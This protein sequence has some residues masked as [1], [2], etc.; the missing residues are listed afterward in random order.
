MKFRAVLAA[1]LLIA[2]GCSE[3]PTQEEPTGDDADVCEQAAQHRAECVGDYVTPPICEG[4]AEAR[5]REILET[6]CEEFDA[7]FVSSGKADGAFC[8]WFG[9]GCTA[10]EAIF[11]GPACT[12]DADCAGGAFCVE[13]HCFE[14]VTSPEFQ[15]TLDLFTE[16]YEI[17]GGQTQLLTDNALTRQLRNDLV[18]QAGESVHFSAFVIKDDSMG[19]EMVETFSAAAQRGVDV[20]VLIDANTQYTQADYQ[21]LVDMAEAGVQILAW[22]PATEWAGLRL[23]ENFTVNDRMHEKMLI[24]DG[25]EAVIGGRNVGDPYLLPGRWRDTD[26]YVAGTS[27]EG[28]QRLFLEDWD[29]VAGYE[30]A[31]GCESQSD[32]GFACPQEELA[33]DAA[34]YPELDELGGS[35]TR[36]IFS[37]PHNQDTPYGYLTTLALIR[38]ARKSV[39]IANSYFVPPRR[40]RRHLKAAAARGVEVKVLTNSLESTD[41][42]PMYYASLNFYKELIGAGVEIYQYGGTEAMHAKTMLIDDEVAVIGSFNLDPRSAIDNT[43]SMLLVR[44]GAAVQ[45]LREA[46]VVDFAYS[47]AASADI[48]AGEL[49]KAKAWRLAEPLL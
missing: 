34:Q 13:E 15:E 41:A 47:T 6:P 39:T 42:W 44:E 23:G 26:V 18:N 10:D 37:D 33:E 1:T 24:V 7:E 21:M 14:G 29:R 40:L 32:W 3:P 19:Q 38:G 5:A 2:V 43:E 31:T 8:D 49:A 9:L 46:M 16:S 11:V 17:G 25:R 20:R 45:Q 22:N 36:A 35:I 4:D 27:V 48:P 12:S 28:I 30:L